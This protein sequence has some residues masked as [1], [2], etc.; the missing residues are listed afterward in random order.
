VKHG[1]ED[2]SKAKK[3]DDFL[4][5]TS[6]W[7]VFWCDVFTAEVFNLEFFPSSMLWQQKWLDQFTFYVKPMWLQT[8]WMLFSWLYS[9]Q[10]LLSIYHNHDNMELSVHTKPIS[11]GT[12]SRILL[13]KGITPMIAKSDQKLLFTNAPSKPKSDFMTSC[14]TRPLGG[15]NWVASGW[16][17][18]FDQWP[19][20]DM[21]GTWERFC[22]IV[23]N[24]VQFW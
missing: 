13:C 14:E 10:D 15:H 21:I 5:V 22:H 24:F 8:A 17:V 23:R 2:Q 11:L 12:S 9:Y 18:E 7:S 1:F 3:P 6:F 20:P 19:L 4:P 16:W